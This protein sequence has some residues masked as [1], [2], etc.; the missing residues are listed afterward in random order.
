V[1]LNSTLTTN[2]NSHDADLNGFVCLVVYQPTN[3]YGHY[4]QHAEFIFLLVCLGL[5]SVSTSTLYGRSWQVELLV[6]VADD[7]WRNTTRNIVS[8][9]F[10]YNT[11]LVYVVP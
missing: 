2:S 8:R 1:C 5:T 6:Q 10:A 9:A 11:Q 3:S 7:G 4:G